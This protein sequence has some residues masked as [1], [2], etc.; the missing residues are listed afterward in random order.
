ME[1]HKNTVS[2]HSPNS[3]ATYHILWHA[4]LGCRHLEARPRAPVIIVV[5]RGHACAFSSARRCNPLQLILDILQS[6]SI[7]DGRC[8]QC[9]KER[10][11][12]ECIAKCGV[13]FAV[14][15]RCEG[16]VTILCDNDAPT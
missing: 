3:P 7:C 2:A 9:R 16:L 5:R 14:M 13:L 10:E 15:K 12:G 1:T 6:R 11:L 8:F 4:P